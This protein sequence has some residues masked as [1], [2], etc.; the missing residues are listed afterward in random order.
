[1]KYKC[2]VPNESTYLEVDSSMVS[3]VWDSVYG[4]ILTLEDSK[5]VKMFNSELHRDINVFAILHLVNN[6]N[7]E[8]IVG[9][10]LFEEFGND[11]K[12]R[13]KLVKL[14]GIEKIRENA[15]VGYYSKVLVKLFS[16]AVSEI[17]SINTKNIFKEL[18][19]I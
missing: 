12:L 14:A 18:E 3:S 6:E 16:N 17:K 15:L 4:F 19:M 13:N 7:N 10:Y 1:M 8:K 2:W 9:D 11:E 5:Y